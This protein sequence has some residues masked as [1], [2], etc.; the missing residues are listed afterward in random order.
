VTAAFLVRS[1]AMSTDIAKQVHGKFKLF[2]GKL[3]GGKSITKLS[4]EVERF[5]A[6]TKAAP[7]SIGIEYLEHSKTLVLTLGYRD[8]E[9]AYPVKLGTVSLGKS[10]K[11]EAA[12]LAKLE[13]KLADEAAKV[14][15]IIC[16]ELFITED[17]EFI[18][19]FMTHQAK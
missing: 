19:V 15:N 1:F 3:E 11:L 16:H 4:E 17:D 18:V 8:D 5:A 12:D 6:Q 13:A 9:S 7:K 10:S 14:K 2:T